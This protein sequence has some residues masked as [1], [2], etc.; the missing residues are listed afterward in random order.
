L[1]FTDKFYHIMLH[2]VHLAMSEIL[3]HNF[4]DSTDC[5]GSCKSNNNTNMTMTAPRVSE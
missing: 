2:R 3:T 5:T 4:V 1:Q